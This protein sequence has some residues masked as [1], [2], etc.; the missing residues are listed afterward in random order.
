MES[1]QKPCHARACGWSPYLLMMESRDWIKLRCFPCRIES[2][3]HADTHGT[4]RSE[5]EYF[6]RDRHG[7]PK[8]MSY[9]ERSGYADENPQDTAERTQYNS[10]SQKLEL[11]RPCLC[12]DGHAQS[13]FS[14][15]FCH[16]DQHDI[17]DSDPPH[18]QRDGSDAYQKKGKGPVR[19]DLGFD[20]FFRPADVEI[21]RL[22]RSDMMSFA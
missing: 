15:S 16:R 4:E 10:L 7:P 1:L 18:K 11:N 19:C 2:E 14:G 9:D 17:H 13:Y 6:R 3:E 5:E 20:H 8:C 22:T 21:I 12:S